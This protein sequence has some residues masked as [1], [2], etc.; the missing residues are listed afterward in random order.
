M[1]G[2]TPV[3]MGAN[4]GY[5]YSI[6]VSLYDSGE[7]LMPSYVDDPMTAPP[8][9]V[10]PEVDGAIALWGIDENAGTTTEDSS[11]N[12]NTG[13]ICGSINWGIGFYGPA[14]KFN[15]SG[16]GYVDCGTNA[17]LNM[18][19]NNFSFSAWIMPVTAQGSTEFRGILGGA[20]GAA[21]FG[22]KGI[23]RKLTFGKVDGSTATDS[24]Y[25]TPLNEW[26]HVAVTFNSTATT[27][28]LAYYVNGSYVTTKTF[29]NDFTGVTNFIGR[30]TSIGYFFDGYIDEVGI[31]DHILTSAEIEALAE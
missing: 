22:L 10:R 18:G 9:I 7:W 8:A 31:Y 24:G 14:V 1:S 2:P 19:T 5:M 26:T 16:G 28:N 15:R 21:V 3:N 6:P 13:T 12:G 29:N 4:P 17:S 20:S 25:P 23:D 30:R 27:Y 11:G